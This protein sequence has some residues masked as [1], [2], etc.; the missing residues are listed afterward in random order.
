TVPL[1]PAEAVEDALRSGSDII[2]FTYNEPLINYEYVLETS[3]LAREKGL[4]TAI[5]SGGYVNPEPLRELLPHLDAVKFD[6]KGFSEEFYRKLT[7]GSLAPVL[8]AARLTH[9]S[10]TWL[11]IVYLI[12]PG[13]NDDETQLRGIS[14]WI[15]DELDADVPLHFTR[16]HPDY[17]LTSVPATP[18]TTL[19]E[20]RR[21]ALEEGL[22]HV[23]AGNIPDV[24]TNTTYCADGSV[25]ISRSGFFVQE[26]N[27]LRGRCPDGSTIPGLWE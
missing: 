23:Y 27:L 11:E 24:E 12:I 2:A 14:R 25:A 15:R 22:R 18:L 20:A 4:R 6:I 1:S 7:S 26:N 16:F 9:E 3:R 10:G 17:K 8:E 13:E 5:V 19:Y 21:L